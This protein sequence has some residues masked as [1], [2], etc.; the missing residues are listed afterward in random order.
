MINTLVA[1]NTA[2][3]GGGLYMSYGAAG[4]F[5][6]IT[7]QGNLAVAHGG[8]L[9]CDGCAFLRLSGFIKDNVARE[10]RFDCVLL[11]LLFVLVLCF[12]GFCI[13]IIHYS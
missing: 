2:R 9:S 12:P 6:N 7:V 1:N 11:F 10:V 4:C 3:A 5:A 8:G 13:R